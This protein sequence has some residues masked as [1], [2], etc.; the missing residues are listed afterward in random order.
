MR[1][2]ASGSRAALRLRAVLYQHITNRVSSLVDRLAVTTPPVVF[3][4][5]M[6]KMARD[7][8][9]VSL[10]AVRSGRLPVERC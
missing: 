4:A 5:H 7:Y 2:A 9:V 3:E 10:D 6:R 1:R 8:E